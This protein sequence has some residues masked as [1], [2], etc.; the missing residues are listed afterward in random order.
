MVS[1]RSDYDGE[2][3][4]TQACQSLG[5]DAEWYTGQSQRVYRLV[6]AL[7]MT[8]NG[9]QVS[10]NGY[11]GLSE[12]WYDTEWYTGWVTPVDWTLATQLGH[13]YTT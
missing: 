6:G 5:N 2:S 1:T 9:I 7:A 12:P 8:Q 4:S 11:T 3:T 10:L 13:F